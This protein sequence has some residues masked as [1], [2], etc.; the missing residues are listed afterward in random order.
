MNETPEYAKLLEEP[1]EH[2]EVLYSVKRFESENVVSSGKIEPR[3]KMWRDVKKILEDIP[4][5]KPPFWKKP[6]KGKGWEFGGPA[7]LYFRRPKSMV[8]LFY[9]GKI[10]ITARSETDT[11]RA[12]GKFKR[13]LK[14][15]LGPSFKVDYNVQNVVGTGTLNQGIECGA[16]GALFPSSKKAWGEG[17]RV[18]VKG[19]K[20]P[21]IAYWPSGKVVAVGFK[22]FDDMRAEL[23]K[24]IKRINKNLGVIEK[25]TKRVCFMER[26]RP[27]IISYYDLIKRVDEELDLKFTTEERLRGRHYLERFLDEKAKRKESLG[28]NPEAIGAAALYILGLNVTESDK[29]ALAEKDLPSYL[30]KS[31]YVRKLTQKDLSI[32]LDQ[33]DVTLRRAKDIMLETVE[34]LA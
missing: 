10:T 22:S 4:E 1:K 26:T 5:T 31:N 25:E 6:L 34:D 14:E 27:A 21:N 20:G 8:S 11:K 3:P 28:V 17:H 12:I 19:S 29:L 32:L 9:D 13:I 18:Y 24:Q 16:L 2:E 23:D 7:R 33:T 30:P 15:T